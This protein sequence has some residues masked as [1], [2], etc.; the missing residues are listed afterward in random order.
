MTEPE[1]QGKMRK[2][3]PVPG[4]QW[5]HLL[6]PLPPAR[7]GQCWR[8]AWSPFATVQLILEAHSHE[9][10]VSQWT[11]SPGTKL[12]KKKNCTNLDWTARRSNQSILKEINPEYSLEGLMLKLKLQYF[13]HLMR[14][15]DSLEKTLMLGK[16]EGRR[17]RGWQDGMLDGITDTMD[18]TLSKLQEMVMAREADM[19]QSMGS[20]RVR[21]DLATEQQTLIRGNET[22]W[23]VSNPAR[24]RNFWN[25]PSPLS[26]PNKASLK[27][28]STSWAS[29]WLCLEL[30]LPGSCCFC[31][32]QPHIPWAR[33]KKLWFSLVQ[34]RVLLFPI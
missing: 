12:W 27:M 13:G 14:R 17:R 8:P 25:Q 30:D 26:G 16:I 32:L 4:I 18:M 34:E 22:L 6:P 2:V 3:R 24:S 20:Q 23:K 5:H 7:G 33:Y 21:H 15:A 28:F 29:S 11:R 31:L 10:W 9:S 1:L 19:L